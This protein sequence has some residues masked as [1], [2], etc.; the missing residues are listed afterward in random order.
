[1]YV[2]VFEWPDGSRV[3]ADDYCYEL[4]RWRG[5]DFCIIY[6]DETGD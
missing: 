1:M 4:D 5:D 3:Y 6:V 2:K